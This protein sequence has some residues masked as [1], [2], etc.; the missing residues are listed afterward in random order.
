MRGKMSIKL[1]P[2]ENKKNIVKKNARMQQNP[3]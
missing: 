1:D 2:L 3:K